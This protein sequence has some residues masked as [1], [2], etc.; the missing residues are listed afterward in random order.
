MKRDLASSGN[1]HTEQSQFR[2][3]FWIAERRAI[4]R[5]TATEDLLDLHIGGWFRCGRGCLGAATHQCQAE[6]SGDRRCGEKALNHIESNFGLILSLTR[7]KEPKSV[8]FRNNQKVHEEHQFGTDRHRKCAMVP[9][10]TFTLKQ[11]QA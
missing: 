6:Q 9:I 8:A 10:V 2:L 7:K 1:F 5:L 4:Q 3:A 11:N